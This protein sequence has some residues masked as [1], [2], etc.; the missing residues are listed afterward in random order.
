MSRKEKEDQNEMLKLYNFLPQDIIFDDWNSDDF[1]NDGKIKYRHQRYTF[2]LPPQWTENRSSEKPEEGK[3]Y[4]EG[5]PTPRFYIPELP[6]QNIQEYDHKYTD[7]KD[8]ERPDEEKIKKQYNQ[9]GMMLQ[10]ELRNT[11]DEEGHQIRF[12]RY[13]IYSPIE[14]EKKKE[15]THYIDFE[16]DKRQ[17]IE[18]DVDI[19]KIKRTER[20]IEW[21]VLPTK[22]PYDCGVHLVPPKEHRKEK[23]KEKV[24]QL[25]YF[26][27]TTDDLMNEMRKDRL[28]P[29]LFDKLDKNIDFDQVEE[30]PSDEPNHKDLFRNQLG[31]K[32]LEYLS[33]QEDHLCDYIKKEKFYQLNDWTWEKWNRYITK[34]FW[35]EKQKIKE[36]KLYTK[37]FEFDFHQREQ[38]TPPPRP[39]PQCTSKPYHNF[40][41]FQNYKKDVVYQ[42]DD[43]DNNDRKIDILETL[44]IKR[45]VEKMKYQEITDEK[46]H[47]VKNDDSKYYTSRKFYYIGDKQHSED[48]IIEEYNMEEQKMIIHRKTDTY[49]NSG[50]YNYTYEYLCSFDMNSK[51]FKINRIH[52]DKQGN[53]YSL[54]V[55]QSDFQNITET[56]TVKYSSGSVNVSETYEGGTTS[57]VDILVKQTGSQEHKITVQGQLG[58]QVIDMKPNSIDITV[59][60]GNVNINQIGGT[61]NISST[62]SVQ[63][64]SPLI[65]LIGNVVY[66]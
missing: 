36:Q 37:S 48:T 54:K 52:K 65:R 8:I 31:W 1:T 28:K 50:Q 26:G 64:Q 20:Y 5:R 2:R 45:Q 51:V 9:W 58:S 56:K 21:N 19:F 60:G 47:D 46:L 49:D 40:E 55:S 27:I 33:N 61:V 41:D 18:Y 43:D 22:I 15:Y 13:R 53:E 14:D 39:K 57:N 66:G 44:N 11:Y 59:N 12:S 63:I 24:K 42:Y 29:K 4:K 35:K 25:E 16:N 17:T 10:D 7:Y 62:T 23:K 34:D 32:Y 38:P 3:K 30:T 6:K